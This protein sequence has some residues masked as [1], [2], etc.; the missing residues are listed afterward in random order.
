MFCHLRILSQACN[1]DIRRGANKYLTDCDKIQIRQGILPLLFHGPCPLL[2]VYCTFVLAFSSGAGE[3]DFPVQINVGILPLST[4]GYCSSFHNFTPDS[5]VS[6]TFCG[7]CHP[8][9]HFENSNCCQKCILSQ[10]CNLD[11]R[12]GANNFMT[13]CY[14]F[15]IG[16][17]FCPFFV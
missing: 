11:T 2:T 9:H 4:L 14:I 10:T 5:E 3:H 15:Y 17:A 16:T 6:L 13:G 12:V 1:S 7:A 8:P